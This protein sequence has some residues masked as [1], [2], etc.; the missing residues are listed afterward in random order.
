MVYAAIVS[1]GIAP[2]LDRYGFGMVKVAITRR[3]FGE[4]DRCITCTR[5][6]RKPAVLPNI[7]ASRPNSYLHERMGLRTISIPHSYVLLAECA[8]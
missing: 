6:R 5:Y 2:R 7:G 8:E 1:P 4:I 3:R